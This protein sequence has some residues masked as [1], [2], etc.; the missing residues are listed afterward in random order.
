MRREQRV[1]YRHVT[2][3]TRSTNNR[4]VIE[5]AGTNERPK[6]KEKRG[7][8]ERKRERIVTRDTDLKHNVRKEQMASAIMSGCGLRCLT[9]L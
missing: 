9:G 4:G 2:E 6:R 8:I 5:G 3:S 7:K 1:P